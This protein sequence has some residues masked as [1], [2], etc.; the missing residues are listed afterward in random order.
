MNVWYEGCAVE[1]RMLSFSSVDAK[2]RENLTI[3]QKT[4]SDQKMSLG[5][6]VIFST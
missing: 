4:L 5:V 2:K 1:I 3:K 6:N